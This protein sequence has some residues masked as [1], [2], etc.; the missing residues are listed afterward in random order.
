MNN[1]YLGDVYYQANDEIESLE[2]TFN[3]VKDFIND[4][5][6]YIYETISKLK[7]DVEL[8]RELLKKKI[9]EISNKMI[10][11]L[12]NYQK[13][14]NENINKINIEEKTKDLNKEIESNLDE[15]TKDNKRMLIVSSDSKRKEIRSKAIEFDIRLFKRLE[16]L[17]EELM[18]NQ[19]WIYKEN[20]MV[21][22]EFE[23][24]LIQFDG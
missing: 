4:P 10:D 2:T 22:E 21:K 12:E 11:K 19:N 24:E 23:K 15:W 1:A 8:R 9:D 6:F 20:E 13:E 18:M 3:K 7:N 5:K 14:C 17:N 16:E